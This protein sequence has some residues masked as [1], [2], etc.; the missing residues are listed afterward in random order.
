RQINQCYSSPMTASS[1][2]WIPQQ[3]SPCLLKI[4]PCPIKPKLPFTRFFRRSIS[5][6]K[7]PHARPTTSDQAAHLN[8]NHR[9][10]NSDSAKVPLFLLKTTH[11][12]LPNYRPPSFGATIPTL[13]LQRRKTQNT[14]MSYDHSRVT[15][16]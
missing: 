11:P 8:R 16:L 2:N 15:T 9:S 1:M 10:T 14:T 13:S 12:P 5:P 6:H 3:R 7:P 4:S